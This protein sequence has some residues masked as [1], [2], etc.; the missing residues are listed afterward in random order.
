M[1]AAASPDEIKQASGKLATHFGGYTAT[2]T[3]DLG[4]R[5]G[6]FAV[7]RDAPAGLTSTELARLLEVGVGYISPVHV[8]ILGRRSSG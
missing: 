7:L 2:W 1:S 6:M 4:V 3:M 8:V 5:A